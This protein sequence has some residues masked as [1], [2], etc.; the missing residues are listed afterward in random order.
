MSICSV[1]LLCDALSRMQKLRLVS[2]TKSFLSLEAGV[3]VNA[4]AVEGVAFA[5]VWATQDTLK[6][7]ASFDMGV[8][9]CFV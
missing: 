3:S 7:A 1:Q 9:S 2:P 8:A 5:F 6:L 4:T